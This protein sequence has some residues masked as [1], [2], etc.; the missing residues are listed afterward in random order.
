M[1]PVPQR[2]LKAKMALKDL[3]LKKLSQLANVPYS[4]CSRILNGSMIHPEYFRRIKKAIRE[5]PT[6]EQLAAA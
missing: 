6:P 3:S 1:T 5:A 4:D 2:K